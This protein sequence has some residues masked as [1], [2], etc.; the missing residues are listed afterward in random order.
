MPEIVNAVLGAF[1]CEMVTLEPPELVSVSCRLCEFPTCTLPKLKLDGVATRDPGAVPDPESGT[2]SVGLEASLVI[3]KLP[4][5]DPL[6][7][8][9]NV[10]LNVLLCPAD[11][12]TGMLR[13]PMEYPAPVTVAWLIVAGDPPEFV[14]VAES[15]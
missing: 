12:V 15:I 5:F 2:V 10:M 4:L 11:R 9:E 3:D 1:T 13:L 7:W 8:G 14:T 6:D